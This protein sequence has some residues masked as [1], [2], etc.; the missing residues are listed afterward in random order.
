MGRDRSLLNKEEE[1]ILKMAI[2]KQSFK[3]SDVEIVLPKL[4]PRQRTHMVEKL[5][6]NGMIHPIKENG[7][8]YY[9]AFNNNYLMRSLIK[10]LEREDFIPSI[11]E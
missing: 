8:E 7:R 4:T 2:K 11:N 9:V 5:K 3:S 6:S 10:M 1:A